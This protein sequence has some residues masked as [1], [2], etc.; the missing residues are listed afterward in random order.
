MGAKSTEALTCKDCGVVRKTVRR[1]GPRC[2]TCMREFLKASKEKAWAQRIL[3][4]YGITPKQYWE[5][6]DK[7][8]GVCA[9][10]Q[11]AT[12]KTKR[13]AVDHDHQTGLVRGLLCGPCNKDVIGRVYDEETALRVVEYFRNPPAKKLLGMVVYVPE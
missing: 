6:Y 2:V 8:G 1:P 7:Q 11:R 5:L 13:L 10:C 3:R 12:G 9:V 4:T